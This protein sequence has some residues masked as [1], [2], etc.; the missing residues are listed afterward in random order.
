M[1]RDCLSFRIATACAISLL[2]LAAFSA[3]DAAVTSAD[4]PPTAAQPVWTNPS[5]ISRPKLTAPKYEVREALVYVRFMISPEGV[6]VEVAVQ[7]DRGFHSEPFR[8]EALRYVR[9]MRFTPATVDGVPT[10]HGPMTQSIRFGL[11]LAKEEQGVTLEFRR[12]LDKVASLMKDRDYA[13]AHFHA[14]WMLREKVTLGYEYAVLQAQLA[15]TLA[16]DGRIDEALHAARGATSRSGSNSARFRIGEPPPRNNPDNYL[17]PKKLVVYLL[18]L[19]MRLHAQRGDLLEALNTYNELAGL[20][21]IKEG[22]SRKALADKLVALL[23]SG[24]ALVFNGKVTGE[25]WSHDLYHPQFTTQNVKGNLDK[26][27]LHCRGGFKE[28]GYVP[29]ET[30]S[31]QADLGDCTVE[32]YG[33]PGATLELVELP[34][35]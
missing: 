15:Q 24:D 28:F 14:E 9:G 29:G 26:V 17:L 2:P 10:L 19:R 11:G 32:F 1:V 25:Y 20:D 3:D 33:E 16:A 5:V 12:E 35:D 23:Q 7:D 6:P 13:G 31:L 22:D 18:E 8:K 27:H 34:A 4:S 30:W 21:A